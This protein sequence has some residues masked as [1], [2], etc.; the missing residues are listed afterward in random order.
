LGAVGTPPIFTV[1][2]TFPRKTFSVP[3]TFKGWGGAG[4]LLHLSIVG[5]VGVT[6]EEVVQNGDMWSSGEISTNFHAL[7]I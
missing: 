1:A 6:K 4:A 2:N 7:D 5:G 3:R